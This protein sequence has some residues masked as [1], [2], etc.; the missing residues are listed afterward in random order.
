MDFMGIGPF[1][2]LF[3]LIL[4]FLFFGPEKLPDM[5]AKAGRWYRN[6]RKATFDISKTLSEEIS[7]ETKKE[8][9]QK[10]LS[11]PEPSEKRDP[12]SNQATTPTSKTEENHHE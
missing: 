4:A 10:T 12:A 2:L 7:T 8:T 1:E 3:I 5:A 11:A 6:F 9:D